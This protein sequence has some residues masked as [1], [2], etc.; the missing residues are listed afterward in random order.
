[1]SKL[2]SEE[3]A[4]L[5]SHLLVRAGHLDEEELHRLLCVEPA[6]FPGS[7]G[8]RCFQDNITDIKAQVAAN[9]CGTR[10]MRQ[11]IDEYSLEVVQVFAQYNPTRHVV[12]LY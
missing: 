3:G 8:S 6:R 12:N 7:S 9:H 2:L 1:M 5:N 10:L 4:I 11:L